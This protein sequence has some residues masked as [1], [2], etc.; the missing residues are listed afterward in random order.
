MDKIIKKQLAKNTVIYFMPL[1]HLTSSAQQVPEILQNLKEAYNFFDKSDQEDDQPGSPQLIVTTTQ[2][3]GR[4]TI[5]QKLLD[6]ER[7]IKQIKQTP[8]EKALQDQIVEIRKEL[9]T[10][11]EEIE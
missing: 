6:V 4:E 10:I 8:S 5:D 1:E 7:K 3:L 9:E 2:K 11:N